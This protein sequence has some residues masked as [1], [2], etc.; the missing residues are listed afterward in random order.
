[1][2]KTQAFFRF[3]FEFRCANP[4]IIMIRNA[5][6]RTE[7]LEKT[8]HVEPQDS[9]DLLAVIRLATSHQ[10]YR[11]YANQTLDHRI[12][13]RTFRFNGM[14]GLPIFPTGSLTDAVPVWRVDIAHLSA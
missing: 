11:S 5:G 3:I 9:C 2:T 13:E 7:A 4:Y 12:P 8:R 10:G 1:M 14:V 6:S